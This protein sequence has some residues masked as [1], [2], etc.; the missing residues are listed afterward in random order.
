MNALKS[1]ILLLALLTAPAF[2]EAGLVSLTVMGSGEIP[3]NGESKIGPGAGAQ[4]ILQLG[5]SSWMTLTARSGYVHYFAEDA[6]PAV[7]LIPIMGGIKFPF[8]EIHLY[9]TGEVGAALTH[10]ESSSTAAAVDHTG[11]AWGLGL[12]SE[13][14]PLDLRLSFNVLDMQKNA[15]TAKAIGLMLGFRLWDNL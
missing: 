3:D 4:G 7:N 12:G 14:G 13:V 11:L 9:L 15:E 10:Q 8:Q 2:S 5:T 1:G 6:T